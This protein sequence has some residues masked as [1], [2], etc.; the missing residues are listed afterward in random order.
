MVYVASFVLLLLLIAIMAIGVI[1]KRKP[2]C[3][4][5][6]GISCAACKE[7]KPKVEQQ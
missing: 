2:I 1:F 5:C 4:S 6:G 3:G 7:Q